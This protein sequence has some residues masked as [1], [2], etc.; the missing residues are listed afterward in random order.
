MKRKLSALFAAVVLAVG[1]GIY[2]YPNK[3]SASPGPNNLVS[4]S[5]GGTQQNYFVGSSDAT[6]SKDGRYVVFSSNANNLVA[7]DTNNAYDVFLRDTTA[8]TTVRISVDSSGNQANG[9]SGAAVINPTGNYIAYISAA[10][11][12]VAVDTNGYYDIFLYNVST[13]ATEIVSTDSSGNQANNNNY[14]IGLSDDARF[15]TFSSYAS[16]LDTAATGTYSNIFVKDRVTGTTTLLSKNTSGIA[17]NGDSD[18]PVISCSG[19]F[20]AFHSLANNLDGTDSNGY[21]DIILVDRLSGTVIKNITKTKN[22]VS[23]FPTLS[24]DGNYLAFDSYATNIVSGDSNN[25]TDVYRYDV[26]NGNTIRVSLNNTGSE[27]SQNSFYPS[28][29][30]DGNLVSFTSDEPSG[31]SKFYSGDNNGVYDVFLRNVELSTT[32]IVSV[33]SGGTVGNGQSIMPHISSNGNYI[34]YYS[35]ASNLTTGD[36]NGTGDIYLSGSGFSGCTY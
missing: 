18:K 21:R 7:G 28:L 25:K 35:E 27:V 10:T 30:G 17:G 3:S 1:L 34:T 32:D 6:T 31:S 20:V 14:S 9:R 19:R 8:N 13:G 36:M 16:N 22:G 33:S 12:L 15:V 23:E 26:R 29:S 11:N 2:Y 24:C 5:T 4:I